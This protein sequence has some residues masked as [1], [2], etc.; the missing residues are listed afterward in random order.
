MFREVIR[1]YKVYGSKPE[2]QLSF[3]ISIVVFLCSIVYNF[4]AS[5]Y[6]TSRASNYVEDIVLSNIRVFDVGWIF[7]WGAIALIV[8]IFGLCL[9]HPKRIPFVLHSLSL[10]YFI[11]GTFVSLTHLGPFPTQAE[12]NLNLGTLFAKQFGG[13]DLFF[14]A[15]TGAPFL[16]ALV[17]W[18]NVILRYI[19]LV[20]SAVFGV[21]VLLG[22]FHYSIDVLSAFFITFTIYQIAKWLFPK[23]YTLFHQDL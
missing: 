21:V 3:L 7:I 4:Y 11:R 14:S 18:D 2:V 5:V 13:D 22:H 23:D 8:F 19:F 20:W 17:F 9:L 16:M 12:L 15:H 1:R 10:F 6:A